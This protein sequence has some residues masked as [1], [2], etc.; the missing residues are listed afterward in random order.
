MKLLILL[1]AT[2]LLYICPQSI[3]LSLAKMQ[4]S[5]THHLMQ[6]VQRLVPNP[7]AAY[8]LIL[9]IPGLLLFLLLYVLCLWKA[10]FTVFFIH[11]LLAS[12]C[13]TSYELNHAFFRNKIPT[14]FDS[15]K[16]LQE[17]NV[18]LLAPAIIFIV[19][20]PV[21]LLLHRLH[22][23]LVQRHDSESPSALTTVALKA[24]GFIEWFF[25]RLGCIAFALM[26]DFNK[27]FQLFKMNCVKNTTCAKTFYES[28]AEKVTQSESEESSTLV[29]RGLILRS[30]ILILTC[31]AIY[32][33][34]FGV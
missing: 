30:Y 33:A 12:F 2:I 16:L 24:N 14:H 31:Y 22:M 18:S 8:L 21:A 28:I 9:V 20:G 13:F 4:K 1:A 10:R 32:I 15:A 19:A 26:S 5:L 23:G 34:Q 7:W 17:M 6:S 11:V 27:V 3:E 25:V 29:I